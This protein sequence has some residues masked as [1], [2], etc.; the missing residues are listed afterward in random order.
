MEAWGFELDKGRYKALFVEVCRR[1]ERRRRRGSSSDG[2][3]S[4]DDV[5]VQPNEN[6][7][8]FKWWLG[9]PS[10]YYQREAD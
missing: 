1:E 6:L 7:E 2:C 10:T 5:A 3:E 9:L 8:R 4:E